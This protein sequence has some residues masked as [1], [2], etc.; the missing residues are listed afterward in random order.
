[1]SGKKEWKLSAAGH[2]RSGPMD[3]SNLLGPH[4]NNPKSKG[5]NKGAKNKKALRRAL[6]C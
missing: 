3:S 2:W 6:V 1:M 4:R 5:A